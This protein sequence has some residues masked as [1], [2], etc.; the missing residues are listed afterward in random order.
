M[1]LPSR[2]LL[3]LAATLFASAVA[4][5][6]YGARELWAALAALLAAAALFDA[7][8]R[9]TSGAHGLAPHAQALALGVR[10]R[11]PRISTPR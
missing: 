2:R 1:I 10:T 7:G 8:L 6:V 11:R 5:S 9:A 4:V 3:W